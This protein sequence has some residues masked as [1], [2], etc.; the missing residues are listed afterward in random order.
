MLKRIK[1]VFLILYLGY[2]GAEKALYYLVKLMDKSKFDITVFA[3]M[4]GGKMER[5]FE[6]LGVKVKHPYS[7]LSSVKNVMG[8]VVNHVRVKQ[9]ENMVAN[10][11]E[12]LLKAVTGE[13]YDLVVSYHVDSSCFAVGLPKRGKKIKY[14]H[15]DCANSPSYVNDNRY[16]FDLKTPYDEVICVSS[17]AQAGYIHQFERTD[18]SA[19]LLNPIDS[20][21]V[22]QLANE[23]TFGF[24]PST[25]VCALGRLTKE[26]GFGRLLDVYIMLRKESFPYKLVIMGEGVE[27]ENL[28]RKIK[29][30]QL[31][32]A[33]ILMKY[34]SNP[35]PIIKNSKYLIVPSYAE[36]LSMT[37]M[38]AICL[39]VPVVSTCPSV[40][41]IFGE[42]S[43]GI[44]TDNT[45]E[46]L[47][48]GML[49][50]FDAQFYLDAKRA[51]ERRS[52]YFEGRS[53]AE[54][55]ENLYVE[56]LNKS[57]S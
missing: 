1:I 57:Q 15:A 41:D 38:E 16:L 35:Y 7:Q 54:R 12:N 4:A 20:E 17:V 23:Q 51:A 27:S 55:A 32:D 39:G 43:C 21:E 44:I 14:V 53:M 47:Y 22:H 36:G 9:I 5:D 13:E 45:D 2:G 50:M 52:L 37:A 26:K 19:V 30:N 3:M 6:V 18:H 8:K 40:G 29:D 11:S 10:N 46:A 42:E 34:Q 48:Q 25:Y 49:D 56:I 28:V 24:P 33:V 31:D